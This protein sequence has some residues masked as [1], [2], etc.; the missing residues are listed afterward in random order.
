MTV[1]FVLI[2]FKKQ[3]KKTQLRPDDAVS[4]TSEGKLTSFMYFLL[5]F[6]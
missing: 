3:L 1:S 6:A 2:P 5:A 4:S